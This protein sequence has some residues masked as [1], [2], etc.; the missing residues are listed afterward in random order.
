[1]N[2]FLSFILI[3]LSFVIGYFYRLVLEMYEEKIN[4]KDVKE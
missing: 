4:R 1:M 2:D 3:T